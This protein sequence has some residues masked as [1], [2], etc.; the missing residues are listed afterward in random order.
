M[1]KTLDSIEFKIEDVTYSDGKTGK[2]VLVYI[3]GKNFLDLLNNYDLCMLEG[4]PEEKLA[5]LYAPLDVSS[6]NPVPEGA[7]TITKDSDDIGLLFGSKNGIAKE[8]PFL[9]KINVDKD[10]VR[11]LAYLNPVHQDWD[12]SGIGEFEFSR[13]S[14]QKEVA[15]KLVPYW[16]KE[17][18]GETAETEGDMQEKHELEEGIYVAVNH[19]DDR[20]VVNYAMQQNGEK[21]IK[22]VIILNKFT[23]PV[24]DATIRI[25]CDPDFAYTFEGKIDLPADDGV[26][27]T[28]EVR[29]KTGYLQSLTEKLIG[30]LTAEILI[31]G[32]VI[33]Q[34]Q[35]DVELLAYD[36]WA[37]SKFSPELLAAFVT[38][39]HPRVSV[40][41]SEA[42]KVLQGWK[43]SPSF[44]GYQAHDRNRV[45]D[46]MAAIYVALRNSKIVYNNPPASFEVAQ[47]VRLPHKVLEEKKGTCL[48]LSVLYAACLEAAGLNP[49]IFI[50]DGHAFAGCWLVDRD[51]DTF[52]SGY[53][54][55]YATLVEKMAR[56]DPRIL[57][58]NCVDFCYG[59]KYEFEN[60][61]TNAK[62]YLSDKSEF[63]YVLDIS[64]LRI[65][66]GIR[67]MSI[68]VGSSMDDEMFD[69]QQDIKIVEKA[70]DSIDVSAIESQEP[71]DKKAYA[72]Q[73]YWEKKL[74]DMS[75]SNPLI[76]L[77]KARTVTVADNKG[78]PVKT[79]LHYTN[80]LQLAFN[81][82]AILED[83]LADGY[84]FTLRYDFGR[85]TKLPIEEREIILAFEAAMK[86]MDV[87]KDNEEAAKEAALKAI[88]IA[89]N[90]FI[91]T[92]F[93]RE[94]LFLDDEIQDGEKKLKNFVKIAKRSVEVNGAN[95]LYLIL[96]TL[97]WF[98]EP[99]LDKEFEKEEDHIAYVQD[100]VNKKALLAPL[101]LVPVDLIRNAGDNSYTLRSRQEETQ[102]NITLL[103]FLKRNYGIEIS[104]LDPLP[105]DA[106]GVDID[107]I[108]KRIKMAIQDMPLWGLDNRA[109]LGHFSFA[110]FV[111]WN[112]I[113]NHADK[114]AENKVIDS[115]L[116]GGRKWIPKNED[117]TEENIERIAGTYNMIVPTS[118]D[119][120]QLVAIAKALSGES[121]VLQGPPGTG[122]SQTITNLI[123]N[124]LYNNKKVLFVA[125]KKAALDVVKKRLDELGLARFCLSLHSEDAN[126]LSVLDRLEQT[127][128]T[129]SDLS[130]TGY[131]KRVVEEIIRLRTGLNGIIDAL[132][133][134]REYGCSLYQA[135]ATLKKNTDYKYVIEF[136]KKLFAGLDEVTIQEWNRLIREYKA[137]MREMGGVY[138][139]SLAGYNG[140]TYSMLLKEQFE[141]DITE[142]L[143]AIPSIKTAWKDLCSWA[144]VTEDSMT[145]NKMKQYLDVLNTVA[146]P[147]YYLCGIAGK[148]NEGKVIADVREFLHQLDI[149][150]KDEAG[151]AQY[152]DLR[153]LDLDV[154]AAKTAWQFAE[155]MGYYDDTRNRLLSEL[156]SYAKPGVIIK[157]ENM[158]FNY[159]YIGGIALKRNA[160]LRLGENVK[161]ILGNLYQG[162]DTDI[163]LVNRAITETTEFSKKYAAVKEYISLELLESAGPGTSVRETAKK[164][165]TFLV[166]LDRFNQVYD[167]D[168]S[169]TFAEA[170]WPDKVQTVLTG[171]R[172]NISNLRSKVAYNT[173]AVKLKEAGL[174]AVVDAFEKGK[175]NRDNIDAAFAGGMYY[176]LVMLTVSQDER[177]AEFY[178]MKY[179]E[180]IE[181]YKEVIARYQK[182]CADELVAKLSRNVEEIVN[183][184]DYAEEIGTLKKAIKGK[185]R[186][187][188]IRKL[189]SE[190]ENLLP[191]ISPCMLM[192]PISVA[193]YID[194]D[195]PKFDLVIF[196]EAS[197]I[198]T[199]EA[200]GAIARGKDVIVVGDPK[201]M[202]P[203]TFF[204]TSV[205]NEMDDD[206]EDMESLLID[207]QTIS[208][209]VTELK[210]H[211]RSQHES[212]IAFSNIKYYGNNLYT[213]PTP[214]DLVSEVR[215]VHPEGY[216]DRKSGC[217]KAEA[218]AI[219]AEILRHYRN[220]K[221]RKDSIGVITFNIKQQ[222]YI[223]E[224]LEKTLKL[225]G[226]EDLIGENIP[227]QVF[228]KNLENV[229]GDEADVIL[230]SI[231]YAPDKEGKLTMNFGPL[232]REGGWRRL[233]VAVSR[234]RKSM[235]IYSVLKPE[236]IR[237]DVTAEGVKNLKEF[238]SYAEN[239]KTLVGRKTLT[240]T[241]EVECLVGDIARAIEKMGYAVKCNIG[242]SEFKMDIG[243]V[244]P[245]NSETYLMGILLDSENCKESSTARDRFVLQ[246]SILKGL[247]WKLLRLWI[248][249]WVDDPRKVTMVLKDA[250][251]AET[252]VAKEIYDAEQAEK[253]QQAQTVKDIV[254]ADVE[255]E[256]EAEDT[257]Q[258]VETV[259]QDKVI[260]ISDDNNRV[261]DKEEKPEISSENTAG[262]TQ[263]IVAEEQPVAEEKNKTDNTEEA[264]Q[265][266]TDS[267]PP[268]LTVKRKF[269]R[270][271]PKEYKQA[272][273]KVQGDYSDYYMPETM[274]SLITVITKILTKE[275][276]IARNAL[277][278]KV[279]SL[280]GFSKSGAKVEATFESALQ[281]ATSNFTED[282]GRQFVWGKEQD[283][284]MYN[285][286]R[287]ADERTLEEICSQ[288]IINAAYVA[289][290]E[291][292]S[293]FRNELQRDVAQRFGCKVFT[294]KVESI[295][296]YAIDKAF[297]DDIFKLLNN[298]KIARK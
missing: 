246:P 296:S 75:S 270:R 14:Y 11:W 4:T 170:M 93:E 30:R 231:G 184:I 221:S 192:N 254:V 86:N 67:P 21:F 46:L 82:I 74:L 96:G 104:G 164:V 56:K 160:I 87:D 214:N 236:Q 268:T 114:M 81:N 199:S 181:R 83:R 292:G 33:A 52:S 66:R 1:G 281:Q 173:V 176:H 175:I 17:S 105:L 55:N 211:Y 183:D 88:N 271:G 163:A 127:L 61:N 287:E 132:H 219:V 265:R 134:K 18:A 182:A 241:E 197:Q 239:R 70:P 279:I 27:I 115:L 20:I 269:S 126:K 229:Q 157:A 13:E 217:N 19:E 62:M 90:D 162:T 158:Q 209:P 73:R 237:N 251:E 283:P 116:H 290:K 6:F 243:I 43:K 123:A 220:P 172:N 282:E 285:I 101:I 171:Y 25:T 257:M 295:I 28:P 177:L 133:C 185:G 77:Y 252:A 195:F 51:V 120:S 250:L 139:D 216:Y 198:P 49:L 223:D 169:S 144:N 263:E 97:R 166:K 118:A 190:I 260:V 255:P 179:N 247:G 245:Y 44:E 213:F 167:I 117:I 80:S 147:S 48:D 84:S 54:D 140:T 37:G 155:Q 122:K 227:Q 208:M 187:K 291:N 68:S 57:P 207:C 259:G 151:C 99:L 69:I 38:P 89:I 71:K 145:Y 273:V 100:Y 294:K 174:T 131:Y 238:L 275:A 280:W 10:T 141:R 180:M 222:N 26:N 36:E 215:I 107:L 154:Q 35:K 5:G 266:S 224:L 205:D 284:D 206:A 85:Y 153:V 8:W 240:S 72:K 188:P 111:M 156:Q 298:G 106:H 194:I 135:I 91:R 129:V 143:N 16:S 7:F 267:V 142:L 159:N 78:N 15:E 225:P 137:A 277:R 248:M 289:I 60:A 47:R 41:L 109:Y 45:K 297:A 253:I 34:T 24:K 29:L 50:V 249:D 193:Q 262:T 53:M 189:F 161:A 204:T 288:E 63:Q 121:F 272:S 40:V 178:G 92:S 201:Q 196:D 58:I 230:F 256:V 102:I 152:F 146:V 203:T 65:G 3:N 9:V 39:N 191:H 276:P 218:E 226:N 112:D 76:S 98:E 12:Y 242:N 258:T 274:P 278:A 22:S 124:A 149:Y 235:I 32:T 113:H 138:D 264:V 200:V 125:E 165:N 130:N 108:L 228:I 244:N 261:P 202:P 186:N 150:K 148:P 64:A 94:Q 233:N 79:V 168:M 128:E 119:S 212:L 103:E 293:M 210:W 234:S 31:D 286:Y 23:K 110:K 59:K 42:S 136:D 232:N 95:T 2:G